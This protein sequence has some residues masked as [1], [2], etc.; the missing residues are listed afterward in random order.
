MRRHTAYFGI[1]LALA[2]T[3][4]ASAQRQR[5]SVG[6]PAPRLN[7]SKWVLTGE[8]GEVNEA[9]GG[10]FVIEF[11]ATWCRPCVAAIPKLSQLQD[12]YRDDGLVIIGVTNEDESLVSNFVQRR[13]RDITYS[14][15]LD[16]RD[17]MRRDWMQAAG[18]S[19]FPVAFI[20]DRR[21]R[22]QFIGNPHDDRFHQV[23]EAVIDD[24][25]D[26][27]LFRQA[28]PI[29]EAA[30]S[31]R[32]QR[33]WN[34]AMRH[35][36]QVIALDPRVFALVTL[37]R[38]EMMLLDMDDR[39]AAYTYARQLLNAHSEDARFLMSLARK[40]A[41]D[42]KIPNEKRDL[43]LALEAA[44]RAAGKLGSNNPEG[45]AIRAEVNFHLGKIDE[46]VQ[47]Q[48]RAWMLASPERKSRYE[49]TLR[50]YRDAQSR[51]DNRAGSGN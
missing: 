29:L 32:Q 31:A 45:L 24:R 25:Y 9:K 22:I 35:F 18:Q 46:A 39:E 34:Q 38:F 8:T 49:R 50:A 28:E 11:W 10:V 37:D 27:R 26:A 33:N 21:Q 6:D 30:S 2:L 7:V 36:D 48:R 13:S 43:P 15:V 51:A 20:V 3:A 42:P 19:G 40:I 47:Y 14:I 44:D 23:L 12:R 17:S 16:N 4:T 41:T 1:L 5:L